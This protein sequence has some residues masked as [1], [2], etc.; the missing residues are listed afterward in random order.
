MNADG[1]GVT[2]LTN[3][4]G[5]DLYPVWSAN[6][7]K[8]AWAARRADYYSRIYTM[9]AS[10]GNQT[11]LTN[12]PNANDYEPA[13]SPSGTQL[14]FVSD[15]NHGIQLWHMNAD[16]SGQTQ[17]TD[18][19]GSYNLDPVWS[20][21][22][23]RVAFTSSRDGNEEIYTANPDGSNPT[24]L[25][26]DLGSDAGPAYSPD[27]TKIAFQSDRA[28]SRDIWVMNANGTNQVQ[29]T[30]DP[31]FDSSPAWSPDGTKILFQS[32]RDGD[33]EIFVMDPNGANQTQL[34][35]NTA[36]D[37]LPDWQPLPTSGGA[38]TTPPVLSVPANI[39]VNATSPAGAAVTYSAT[40]TDDTD[41]S[42]SV[43]CT[44]ASGSTFPIG[45]T[46][47]AC[48]ATDGS[49]NHSGGS[50][51][52]SVSGPKDQLVS[53]VQSVLATTN[54]PPAVKNRLLNAA[55]NFNPNNAAQR[56][57]ACNELRAFAV[58]APALALRGLISPA[59][60]TAWIGDAQR[61]RTVLAC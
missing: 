54:L 57:A 39:T 3:A 29:L 30:T 55:A 32:N 35:S 19:V 17:I 22:G 1:T 14:T 33:F 18:T 8:I 48:T 9:T 49:R 36:L 56:R 34:T 10:G 2:R 44:P 50:F 43:A 51:T 12:T 41:P 60:A 52:V 20:P 6:G 58:A 25:T 11:Q 59:H 42:P 7:S 53:L 28:G 31:G 16:G 27:G 46:T 23:S 4:V 26:N 40:A 15:R 5:E 45:T 24:R 38:D 21:D 47:V 37:R 61:I 13:W